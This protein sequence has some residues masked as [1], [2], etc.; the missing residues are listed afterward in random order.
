MTAWWLLAGCLFGQ[1]KGDVDVGDE[2]GEEAE[3]EPP[4]V[5]DSDV[6]APIETADTAPEPPPV[7]DTGDPWL[8]RIEMQVTADDAWQLWIDGTEYTAPNQF[9]WTLND[10]ISVEVPG[11][12]HVISM[13]VWDSARV[14]TGTLHATW[15]STELYALSGDGKWRVTDVAPTDPAW[16]RLGFDDSAW[17]PLTP[18]PPEEAATW[19]T[20][21]N[22]D[23]L[24]TGAQ[25]S[26]TGS[27]RG[28]G[29]RWM[30]LVVE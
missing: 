26:W 25:W 13:Y 23:L 18:C 24:A 29:Q 9:A 11:R 10:K 16:Q 1:V 7:E 5:V 15:V 4:V 17:T 22:A 6:P 30:R 21:W 20:Y 8:R 19:G 28:L 3:V 27:C 2:V 14:I 12:R